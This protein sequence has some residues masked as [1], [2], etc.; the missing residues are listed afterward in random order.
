MSSEL[1][2][3]SSELLNLYLKMR[4][5]DE[6]KSRE[7]LYSQFLIYK[8]KYNIVIEKIKN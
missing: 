4:Y 5:S 1:C 2:A 8:F 6:R 7:E 3:V